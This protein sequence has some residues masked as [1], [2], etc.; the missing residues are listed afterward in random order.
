MKNSNSC[1]FKNEIATILYFILDHL[2]DLYLKKYLK[3]KYKN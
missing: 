3:I 2:S 1:N